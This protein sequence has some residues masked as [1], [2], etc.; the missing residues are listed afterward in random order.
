MQICRLYFEKTETKVCRENSQ[1]VSTN[2]KTE[3]GLVFVL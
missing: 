1:D 2:N 3:V